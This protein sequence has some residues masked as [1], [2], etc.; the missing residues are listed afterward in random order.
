V[1]IQGTALLQ[2]RVKS[3]M[4]K[5]SKYSLKILALPTAEFLIKK[6]YKNNIHYFRLN[7]AQA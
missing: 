2:L 6:K 4:K 3:S 5:L 7:K 1:D